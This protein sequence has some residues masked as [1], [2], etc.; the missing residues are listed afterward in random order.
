MDKNTKNE[1]ETRV[2]NQRCNAQLTTLSAQACWKAT[3]LGWLAG[4][5]L[6]LSYHNG[7]TKSN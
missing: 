2:R 1:T 6:E 4:K 3:M 7:Y 5:E